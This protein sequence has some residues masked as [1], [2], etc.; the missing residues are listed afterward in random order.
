MPPGCYDC[1]TM[2]SYDIDPDQ[3]VS[4]AAIF[5]FIDAALIGFPL[6]QELFSSIG[7]PNAFVLFWVALVAAL[8][9]GGVGLL[10]GLRW[11]WYVA[12]AAIGVRTLLDLA[13]VSLLGLLFDG[14]VIFLLTRPSVRAKFGVR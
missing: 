12:I 8:I 1:R 3:S 7:D 14:L 9:A 4:I 10:K 6:L 5:L 13:T 11:G 2:A